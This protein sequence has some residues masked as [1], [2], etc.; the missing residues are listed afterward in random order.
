MGPA[1]LDGVEEE[2]VGVGAAEGATTGEVEVEVGGAGKSAVVVTGGGG[3]GAV[4]V[5]GGGGSSTVVVTG[6]VV[7]SW[8]VVGVV[9]VAVVTGS[10]TVT[11]VLVGSVI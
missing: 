3:K 5:A 8:I 11:D 4:V 6:A 10:E 2:R 9:S 1:R 7:G